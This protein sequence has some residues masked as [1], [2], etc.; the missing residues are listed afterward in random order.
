MT[1]GII[2]LEDISKRFISGN[3][4]VGAISQV[5][6]TVPDGSFCVVAGAS[7]SGKTTLL[8]LIGGL[9][10]PTSGTISVGSRQLDQMN[11][12]ALALFRRHQVG[13]I[14][15]GNNLISTLTALEN[16]EIPLILTQAAHSRDLAA[17]ALADVGLADKQHN[18]P[19][20]LSIGEQQRIAIARAMVH[21][22]AIVLA[23]EPTANLDSKTGGQIQS[24]LQQ[25]NQKHGC[26]IIISTHDPQI[27]KKHEVVIHLA[28]GQVKTGLEE[29][30]GE[31]WR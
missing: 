13:Y 16:V 15:Q 27:I 2:I 28:D 6:L 14:F 31:G 23:D 25:L 1:A 19:Q 17:A 8:N 24:L 4:E 18:F 3:T 12:H 22:P 30:R 29:W 9:E 20:F 26:T 7:G 5:S 21:A 10:R 11:E